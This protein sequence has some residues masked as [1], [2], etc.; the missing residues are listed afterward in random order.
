MQPSQTIRRKA[1]TNRYLTTTVCC[2]LGNL[3]DLVTEE[4]LFDLPFVAEVLQTLIHWLKAVLGNSEQHGSIIGLYVVYL[5]S[6]SLCR[7]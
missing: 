7:L 2:V 6:H 3:L 5:T 4:F 1:I